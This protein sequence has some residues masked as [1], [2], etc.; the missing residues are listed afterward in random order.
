M[1]RSPLDPD[2]DLRSGD[3][4]DRGSAQTA[5]NLAL[6]LRQARNAP[7]IRFT[8]ACLYCGEAVPP[9][10]RF[11]EPD[12]LESMAL[13]CIRSWEALQRKTRPR[14]S[15]DAVSWMPEALDDPEGLEP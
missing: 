1:N 3:E 10:L 2:T 14:L 9:P 4:A 12:V 8:G 13:S 6:A 11:C 5:Q 15:D 7:V